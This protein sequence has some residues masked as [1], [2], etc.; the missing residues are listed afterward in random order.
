MNVEIIIP[1]KTIVQKKIDSLTAPG[2]E[3]NFQILP[4]HIDFVSSLKAGI[5]T[6]L[7]DGS[8]EYY[9]INYGILVKK[10]DRV[11][12]VCQQVIRG[13]SLEKLNQAVEEKLSVLSEKEKVT[14]E[15]LSRMEIATLKRISEME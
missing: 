4:R 10:S 9:A 13:E 7:V 2:T 1:N 8:E 15:I 14:N 6:L 12:V 3:G 5:L 11:F